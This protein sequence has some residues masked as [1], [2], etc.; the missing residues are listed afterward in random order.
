[1]LH[2][3]A[4]DI[5]AAPASQ[6]CNALYFDD[7]GPVT[8]PARGRARTIVVKAKYMTTIVFIFVNLQSDIDVEFEFESQRPDQHAPS[9]VVFSVCGAKREHVSL[10][11]YRRSHRNIVDR[12]RLAEASRDEA[13]ERAVFCD[14][15][16]A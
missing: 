3:R 5:A 7:A 12:Q 15:G 4:S 16:A 13:A 11:I 8:P 10:R 2:K 9:V 14:L 6:N 1:V